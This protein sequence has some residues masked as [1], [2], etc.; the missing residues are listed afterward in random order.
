MKNYVKADVGNAKDVFKSVCSTIAQ[1]AS[2][3]EGCVPACVV[4]TKKKSIPNT[5]SGKVQRRKTK[6]FFEEGDLQIIHAWHNPS[7]PRWVYQWARL[8]LF[9]VISFLI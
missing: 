5:T 1:N 3:E 2:N 4:L 8:I 9:W 7:Q 6:G